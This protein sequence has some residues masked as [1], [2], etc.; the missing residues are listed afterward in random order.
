MAFAP[1]GSQII[2]TLEKLSGRA[3]IVA[4]TFERLPNGD[5]DFDWQGGMEIFYDD[6]ETV[7]VHGNRVFLAEDGTEWPEA[8]VLVQ[9][10]PPLD[11]ALAFWA[12]AA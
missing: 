7:V 1:N 5:L 10:E 4:D 12:E 11:A 9:D 6:Q 3:E 2:G 8:V